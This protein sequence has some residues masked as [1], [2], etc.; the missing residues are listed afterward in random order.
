MKQF[1][2]LFKLILEGEICSPQIAAVPGS[3]FCKISLHLELVKRLS[4][5]IHD[6]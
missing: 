3:P 1:R 5:E 2:R 6:W 4:G